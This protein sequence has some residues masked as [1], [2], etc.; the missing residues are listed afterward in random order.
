MEKRLKIQAG[1]NGVALVA[2]SVYVLFA[3][4]YIFQM[5]WSFS[6]KSNGSQMMFMLLLLFSPLT[7]LGCAIAV[8]RAIAF[9]ATRKAIRLYAAG[10]PVRRPCITSVILQSVDL[11]MTLNVLMVDIMFCAWAVVQPISHKVTFYANATVSKVAYA[12][13]IVSIVVAEGLMLARAVTGLIFAIKNLKG[14]KYGTK[15]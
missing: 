2:A 6:D 3:L 14:G 9:L 13:T 4:L 15:G 8:I 10:E 11:L 1:L 5:I 7:V 12:V